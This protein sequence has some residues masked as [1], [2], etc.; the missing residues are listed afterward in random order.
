MINMEIILF[1]A[2]KLKYQQRQSGSWSDVDVG[3]CDFELASKPG[4]SFNKF[5]SSFVSV[6]CWAEIQN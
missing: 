2:L 3:S 1:W 4:I 5:V 6:F